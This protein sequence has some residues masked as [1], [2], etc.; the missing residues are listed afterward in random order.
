[1]KICNYNK[2]Y[3]VHEVKNGK[4]CI[5]NKEYKIKLNDGFYIIRKLTLN[6]CKRLQTVPDWY[7]FPVSDSQAYKMLGNGWTVDVI[8][9]LIKACLKGD[10][11]KDNSLF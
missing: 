3:P 2:E 8:A 5:K 4:I 9:H 7:E 10:I 11:V 6:E 1:M